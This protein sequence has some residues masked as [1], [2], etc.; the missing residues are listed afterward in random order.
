MK[1]VKLLAPAKINLFLE[2]TGKRP[3]GY[4]N[5]TTLFGKV[6]IFDK[7]TITEVKPAKTINL[8]IKNNSGCK[9]PS[10]KNNIVVK[11]VQEFRKRFGLDFG[12]NITLEKNIPVGAGLGGGSSDAAS[13]LIGLCRLSGKCKKTYKSILGVARK[14]G[15]DVSFFLS[16]ETFCIGQGIGDILFP[17]IAKK[18]PLRIIIAY[19]GF[20]L[21]A[22]DA[23]TNLKIPSQNQILTKLAS[24]HKLKEYLKAGVPLAKWKGHLFNRLETS[25]ITSGKRLAELRILADEVSQKSALMSGSGSSI[26]ALADGVGKAKDIAKELQKKAKMVFDTCF[27]REET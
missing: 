26:F 17:V 16:R 24:L 21:Q 7:L 25:V 8:K 20:P 5:I 27:L 11:A 22:K 1:T 3:D 19:P 14:L 13:T 9:L 15:A 23:Y 2:V 6:A 4:H 12:V 10:F 18:V